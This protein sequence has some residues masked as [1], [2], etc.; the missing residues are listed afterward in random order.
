MLRRWIEEG[1]DWPESAIL[2]PKKKN[3]TVLGMLPKD[4]Y[5]EL[6][7]SPGKVQDEFSGYRQE[8]KTS[9]VNFEMLPIKGGQFTMGSSMDDPNR[10]QNEFPAHPVQVSDFWMGKHEVTWEEYELWMLNL[11]KD[12]REYNNLEKTESDG[13]ADAVTKP[14]SLTPTCLSAWARMGIRRFA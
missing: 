12:N 11:D 9:K 5:R 10:G 1:A 14:T 8:I 2:S 6:G 7:F 4:L 13:L 3:F